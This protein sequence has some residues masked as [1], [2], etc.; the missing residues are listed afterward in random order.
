MTAC[1]IISLAIPFSVLIMVDI[2]YIDKNYG[3]EL[4]IVLLFYYLFCNKHLHWVIGDH[5][6]QTAGVY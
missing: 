4:N 5:V 3:I 6:V 2:K 1:L